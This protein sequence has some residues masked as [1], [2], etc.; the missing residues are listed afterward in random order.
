MAMWARSTLAG[1]E[2]AIEAFGQ[3]L[4]EGRYRASMTQ[5]SLEWRSGVDQSLISRLERGKAPHASLERVIR[6]G[7]ALG[8]SFP[9]GY[10][11]HEH[12]CFYRPDWEP[13]PWEGHPPDQRSLVSR[14]PDD[15]VEAEEGAASEPAAVG[16]AGDELDTDHGID[17]R[18][19]DL[20]LPMP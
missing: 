11:P 13:P 5:M 12:R 1:A 16:G 3:R 8:S 7:Q 18:L 4:R 2:E 9:L 10:C 17:L 20:N 14:A 19:S 6:L 15:Q